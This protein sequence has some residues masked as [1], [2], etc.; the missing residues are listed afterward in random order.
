MVE[1]QKVRINAMRYEAKGIL[2]VEM[3]SAKGSELTPF[4][5]GGHIDVFLSDGLVRQYSLMNDPRSRN[6]YKVA[7]LLEKQ[8]SGGSVFIH[9]SLRVG[10]VI[11]V[12]HP[13]NNFE[14]VHGATSHVFVAG[15]IGITPFVS[16]A[17]HCRHNAMPMKL[18]YCAR[19]PETTAFVDELTPL[20]GKEM[21]VH[22]DEGNPSKSINLSELVAREKDA[23]LYCCGPRGL[24]NALAKMVEQ[25]GGSLITEDF[26]PVDAKTGHV[27]SKNGNFIVELLRSGLTVDVGKGQTII[28]ALKAADIDVE[29]SCEA[30]V[31]G[32]CVVDYLEGEPVHN[33][34]VLMPDEQQTSVALCVAGCKS[35]K[36][37][38]DL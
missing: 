15:G 10:D 12:S 21:L 36:L 6:L 16:M 28:E 26:N 9:D 38:L 17:H 32:T 29:T 25:Q 30:G 23:Q 3:V 22:Y 8:S 14:V 18:Y 11:E 31:C 20:F 35:R 2:S 34:V 4:S 5:A 1:K 13:R 27:S 33:D 37:V 7:V 19:A 24:M